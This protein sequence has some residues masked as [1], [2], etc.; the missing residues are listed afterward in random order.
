MTYSVVCDILGSSKN[1]SGSVLFVS[2]VS[3]EI[4]YELDKK[5]YL[6]I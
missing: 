6:L 4:F 3:E 5:G 1:V 2:G